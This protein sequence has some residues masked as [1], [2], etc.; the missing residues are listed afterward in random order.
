M[1]NNKPC[2]TFFAE[3]DVATP[4]TLRA[5]SPACKASRIR[6]SGSELSQVLKRVRRHPTRSQEVIHGWPA[7][8]DPPGRQGAAGRPTSVF[9]LLAHASKEHRSRLETHTRA[10]APAKLRN[11]SF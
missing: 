1:H 2:H 7:L 8:T 6:H 9:E 4:Q 5:V 10:G 11:S 3:T